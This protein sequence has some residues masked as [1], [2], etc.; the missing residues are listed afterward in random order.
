[1]KY[2]CCNQFRKWDHIMIKLHDF[3]SSCGL[4]S[5]YK[6]P[7]FTLLL[8]HVVGESPLNGC[9]DVFIGHSLVFD[10]SYHTTKWAPVFVLW[11]KYCCHLMCLIWCRNSSHPNHCAQTNF[12]KRET[13]RYS[14]HDQT[15]SLHS[16]HSF[17][18]LK[19]A[20]KE[21][22]VLARL[23]LSTVLTVCG[24]L[25]STTHEIGYTF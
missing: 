19:S 22:H 3:H 16:P 6:V 9:V 24:A 11:L 4:D 18:C 14:H 2:T 21:A 5:E 15:P 7:D 1:M 23:N 17:S 8:A 20:S 10:G 25:V 13:S 12:T